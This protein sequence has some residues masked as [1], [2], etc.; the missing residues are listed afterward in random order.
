MR[1]ADATALNYSL[2]TSPAPTAESLMVHTFE[3]RGKY[4]C[5]QCGMQLFI[6]VTCRGCRIPWG[7]A[8]HL[9]KQGMKTY[10]MYQVGSSV[11]R[12]TV[13]SLLDEPANIWHKITSRMEHDDELMSSLYARDKTDP[14]NQA[15]CIYLK[16]GQTSS[17]K[18]GKRSVDSAARDREPDAVEME[19]KEFEAAGL[20]E[21]REGLAA[22]VKRDPTC[23]YVQKVFD[24]YDKLQ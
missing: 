19:R 5:G 7:R 18:G 6:S 16:T 22:L 11:V 8:L 10:G 14:N 4:A 17:I 24:T 13:Q 3:R 1:M 21:K 23:D 12:S 9:L 20:L 2:T 15:W